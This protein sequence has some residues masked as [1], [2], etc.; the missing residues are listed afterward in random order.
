MRLV[1]ISALIVTVVTSAGLAAQEKPSAGGV[2]GKWAMTIEMDVGTATPSLELEQ[3]GDKLTGTY[4]GR[5]GDYPVAGKITA[6]TLTFSFAMGD[7]HSMVMNFTGELAADGASIKGTADMGE[8]GQ[9][10]WSAARVK[11]IKK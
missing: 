9:N 11:E 5:Y 2:T 10:K 8:M 1:S 4:S 7:D 6:R 3:D